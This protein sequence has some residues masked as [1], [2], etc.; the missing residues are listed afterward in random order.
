MAHEEHDD[1]P[2]SP[3]GEHQRAVQEDRYPADDVVRH[4]KRQPE[5]PKPWLPR[6]D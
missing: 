3:F 5:E 1:V 6:T 4:V 2:P